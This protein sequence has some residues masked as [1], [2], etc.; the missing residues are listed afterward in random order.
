MRLFGNGL[1]IRLLGGSV[2]Y[3]T[4]GESMAIPFG[5]NCPI[6]EQTADG[7]TCGRCWHSLQNDNCIRHG[8]VSVEINRYRA[9]KGLTL[10]NEMRKRK[11]QSMLCPRMSTT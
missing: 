7:V 11:G 6:I 3:L 4:K 10:E 2:N 9:G 8:D 5:N 1:A